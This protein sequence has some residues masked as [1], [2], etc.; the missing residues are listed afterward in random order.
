MTSNPYFGV[1]VIETGAGASVVLD[2]TAATC[3]LIGTAPIQEVHA[4]AEARAP[5]INQP[6]LIRSREEAAV[7][8]GPHRA[9]YTIPAA[10][11]SIMDKAGTAGIGTIEVV[12]VFDPDVHATPAAV[13]AVD[14]LGS[15]DAA[16]QP[17]GLKHL[18]ASYNRFGR[19]CKIIIAPGF[20]GFAGVRA[21]IEVIANRIRGR[22][23]I[24]APIGA[25]KQAVLEGRGP[26]GAIGLNFDSRRL[27]I[28]WPHIVAVDSDTGE[29]RLDP[30]SSHL[31]GVWLSSIMEY[32]YHHSPSN[33]PLTGIERTEVPVVYIPGDPQSDVQDLRGAGIITVEERYGLGPHTSGNRSSAYPTDSDIRNFLHV[34]LTEDMLDEAVVHFL[35]RFKDRNG[36]PARLEMIEARINGWLA[37]KAVGNDPEISG[38][39]FRFDRTATTREAAANGR[40]FWKLD[41][42]PVGVMER[43]TVDRNIDLKLIANAL[44]LAA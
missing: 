29:E 15:F 4:T 27:N 9:G 2:R 10:L 25:S 23:M 37:A 35:D 3:F 42:A 43:I 7:A 5:Y 36:S 1:E 8:F 44:G 11:D 31:A 17:S 40:F 12:N 14:I 21:E 26:A 38:A 32:G 18:Y 30:Y 39:T 34:Q 24:D 41:W 28:C 13:A 33:R 20:T 16:G 19:F 22:G 6:V